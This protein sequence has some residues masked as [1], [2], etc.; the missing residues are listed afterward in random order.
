M[1][2]KKD[3]G[4]AGI[5]VKYLKGWLLGIQGDSPIKE[6]IQTWEQFC[7]LVRRCFAGEIPTALNFG[8]L[9]LVP[10]LS[11]GEFRGIGLLKV[12]QKLILK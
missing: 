3:P 8:I 9:V 12:I 2:N 7:D 1:R 4:P 6:A 11:T 5:R 10:K